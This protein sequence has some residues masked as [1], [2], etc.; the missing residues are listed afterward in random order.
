MRSNL[1]IFF[2]LFGICSLANAIPQFH[3]PKLRNEIF[4]K[5]C[6]VIEGATGESKKCQPEFVFRGRTYYGCTKAAS[7]FGE[8]WCSTRV[9]PN[10]KEHISGAKFWG[11]CSEPDLKSGLCLNAAQAKIEHDKMNEITGGKI[12]ISITYKWCANQ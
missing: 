3:I 5:E 12:F 2:L 4:S 1:Y 10:T 9:D 6:R 11:N 8:S 7:Q